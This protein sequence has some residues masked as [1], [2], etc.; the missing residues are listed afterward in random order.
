MKYKI[1]ITGGIGSGKSFISSII[2]HMGYPV[3]YS[4]IEA[5]KIISSDVTLHQELI[6]LIGKKVF[7][8]GELNKPYLA[9]KVFNSDYIRQK[10]NALIHP[11]VQQRFDD[12]A[13][14]QKTKLVF[15]E[16]AILFETGGYRRFN[17][18]ILVTAPEDLKISRVISRDNTSADAVKSR[19]ATQWSDEQKLQ[20]ADFALI[21]DGRP[22]LIQVENIIHSTL[23]NI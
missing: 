6:V 7:L 11:K 16:A 12:W 20:L 10:V 3:F 23:Q 9:E 18:T 17:K 22:V 1:G 14:Q 5:K 15:N 4:D 19:M 8:N 2:E 13:L 21:N